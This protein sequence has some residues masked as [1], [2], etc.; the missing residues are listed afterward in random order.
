MKIIIQLMALF[1]SLSI[2]SSVMAV[3][4]A[5]IIITKPDSMYTDNNDGT[6]FDT[7]TGLMWQKC[8]LGL[9]G[10]DCATGTQQQLDWQA[11]LNAANNNTNS[12]YTDWRLPNK[13]ELNSLIEYACYSPAINESVFPGLPSNRGD[14]PNFFWSSTPVTSSA[15]GS[16]SVTAAWFVDFNNGNTLP[17]PSTNLDG[18]NSKNELHSVRLVRGFVV[19]DN[20]QT[21]VAPPTPSKPIAE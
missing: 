4:N 6:V 2:S 15:T 21:Q 5:N 9:S 16:S 13:N 1:I 12:G 19:L 8:P 11:A 14:E 10:A 7:N 20:P 18:F 17:S 3:C